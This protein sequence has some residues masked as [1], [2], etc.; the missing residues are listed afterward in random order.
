M[1]AIC[2]DHCDTCRFAAV[3]DG[4]EGS[5]AA[6]MVAQQLHNDIAEQLLLTNAPPSRYRQVNTTKC[7]LVVKQSCSVQT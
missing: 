3:Y 2:T 5:Q 7:L 6:S 1:P 4:H